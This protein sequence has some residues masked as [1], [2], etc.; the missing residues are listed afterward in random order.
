MVNAS[1]YLEQSAT[2]KN[3]M[4]PLYDRSGYAKAWLSQSGQWM[5]SLTGRLLAYVRDDSIYDFSGNHVAWWVDEKVL[6]HDGYIIFVGP[7]IPHFEAVNRP[8]H[9]RPMRPTSR[10][11]RTIPTLRGKPVKPIKNYKWGDSSHFIERLNNWRDAE[12]PRR[13]L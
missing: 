3:N 6:S 4:K 7:N 11:L 9:T 5:V 8:Y 12:S 13:R 1:F 2:E 10:G